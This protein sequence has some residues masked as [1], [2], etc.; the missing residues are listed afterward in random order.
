MNPE[1]DL[2]QHIE[3]EIGALIEEDLENRWRDGS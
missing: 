3:D 2:E 1:K